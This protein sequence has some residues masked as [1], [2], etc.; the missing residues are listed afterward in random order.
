MTFAV[1]EFLQKAS[2]LKVSHWLTEAFL[3]LLWIVKM[4][5]KQPTFS[6]IYCKYYRKKK[7]MSWL[8]SNKDSS[9]SNFKNFDVPFEQTQTKL[10]KG[11]EFKLNVPMWTFAFANHIKTEERKKKTGF[12]GS[13]V[14]FF[15][16]KITKQNE[17]MKHSWMQGK[18]TGNFMDF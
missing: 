2:C 18:F 14:H 9:L 11:T 12:T 7:W 1:S 17:R 13:E 10:Q 3:F 16:C 5:K 8:F 4:Y 6:N 15:F